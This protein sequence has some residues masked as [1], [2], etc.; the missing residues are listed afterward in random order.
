MNTNEP[1]V[2]AKHFLYDTLASESKHNLQQP[3]QQVY[4]NTS[5]VCNPGPQ[6]PDYCWCS[7]CR[8]VCTVHLGYTVIQSRVRWLQELP[9]GLQVLM[10]RTE[11]C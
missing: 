1:A 4:Y 2:Q 10:T 7:S 5:V 9:A 8:T 6:D 3:L 11:T